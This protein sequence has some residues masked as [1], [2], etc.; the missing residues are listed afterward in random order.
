MVGWLWRSTVLWTIGNDIYSLCKLDC[1]IGNLHF[2]MSSSSEIF[3]DHYNKLLLRGTV[4]TVLAFLALQL[5]MPIYW[6]S[7]V[8]IS[9]IVMESRYYTVWIEAFVHKRKPWVD[10][11]ANGG[12]KSWNKAMIK[13]RTTS[14]SLAWVLEQYRWQRPV[15]LRGFIF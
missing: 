10:S 5:R 12:Q 13:A 8:I 1:L 11:D 14:I 2:L 6:M 4:W 3:P 15:T 9:L 7:A